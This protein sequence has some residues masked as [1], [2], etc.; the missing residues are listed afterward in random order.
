MLQ[1][2]IKYQR[3]I[4]QVRKLFKINQCISHNRIK[5]IA[6]HLTSQW[7]NISVYYPHALSPHKGSQHRN[8]LCNLA[9]RCWGS[10]EGSSSWWYSWSGAS[11]GENLA[12]QGLETLEFKEKHHQPVSEHI[13]WWNFPLK[14]DSISY[15]IDA[16][17]VH[18]LLPKFLLVLS[19][20]YVFHVGV[21]FHRISEGQEYWISSRGTAAS[22]IFIP[23]IFGG[24]LSPPPIYLFLGIINKGWNQGRLN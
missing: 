13:A 23:I 15:S 17:M 14:Q 11:H 18:H 5:T 16:Q 21:D 24:S 19:M 2:E 20:W 3:T 1:I 22:C 4:V 10:R 8:Q 7:S 9:P 12:G 6:T